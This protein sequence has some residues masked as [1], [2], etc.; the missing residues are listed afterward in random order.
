MARYTHDNAMIYDMT[1]ISPEYHLWD[2]T[3]FNII[4]DQG[5]KKL[6]A[7]ANTC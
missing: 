6:S 2:T 7:P 1:T 3:R 5:N 4:D